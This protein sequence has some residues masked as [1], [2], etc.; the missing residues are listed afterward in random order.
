M[1]DMIGRSFKVASVL[2][3]FLVCS[4]ILSCRRRPYIFCVLQ[5]V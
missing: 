3:V 2:S 1:L 4:L 5:D